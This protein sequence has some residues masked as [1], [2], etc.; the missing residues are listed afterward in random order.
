MMPMP[1]KA[2]PIKNC[3]FCGKALHRK[4]INGRLEDRAV[5]LKRKYCDRTCMAHAFLQQDATLAALR[6]RAREFRGNQCEACGAQEGLQIHHKDSNPANNQ[7]GNLMTL[8]GSCHMKWHWTHGKQPWKKQAAC[9]ICGMPARRLGMC[10]KHYQRYRKYGDPCLTKKKH[11][12]GYELVRE[13]P[14]VLNGQEPHE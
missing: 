11:G 8:C 6:Q 2:D 14:G 3:A 10:Q 4:Q 5:F 1:R 13:T 9:K 12:S 7:S